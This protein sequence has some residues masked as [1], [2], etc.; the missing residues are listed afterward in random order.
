MGTTPSKEADGE[1]LGEDAC[2]LKSSHSSFSMFSKKKKRKANK[3]NSPG[4]ESRERPTPERVAPAVS[5]GSTC[6]MSSSR[7]GENSV[8]KRLDD[9]L[10]LEGDAGTE[11]GRVD[12]DPNNESAYGE[13]MIQDDAVKVNLGMADLMAY[14][15]VVANNSSNLPLTTRDDPELG[16]TVS[17]LTAEEYSLKSRAFVPSDV[18]II[19]G[20]FAKYGRVWDLPTS[21]EFFPSYSTREPGISHGGA[22]CNSLLKVLYDNEGQAI[23][24]S[25]S[26]YAGSTNL[27]EDED[28]I[29]T[30]QTL[31]TLHRNALN[32]SKS[33]DSLVLGDISTPAT[34][35]WTELLRKMKIEMRSVGFSQSPTIT[36]SRKFDTN[37][38][39][40]L[41][42][43]GFD[44]TKNKKLSLLI[45]CNYE[46]SKG[47]ELKASHDDITSVKDYIVNVHGFPET[48]GLMTV[49][50]DDDCHKHPTHSNITDA[51]KALSERCQPGDAVFIQFS[52]HGCR[53]LD[54]PI[55]AD[56]ESYDEA[57]VPS[58]FKRSGIIRDTLIF[59]TLL[60]P[61][62]GG[63]TIT[64]IMDC[65]DTGIMIDL[66]YAWS[67]AGDCPDIISK[68]SLNDNFSFVRFLKVI[69]TLY[70][71][72]TFTQLGQTVR[73]VLDQKNPKLYEDTKT[74]D[75]DDR[76]LLDDSTLGDGS[77]VTMES[78]NDVLVRN[79][80]N[81][82][83][84]AFVSCN[85]PKMSPPRSHLRGG[86]S[87]E[88]GANAQ[89]F[90]QQF[91][92]CGFHNPAESDEETFHRNNTEDDNDSLNVTVDESVGYYREE[93]KDRGLQY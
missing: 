3:E 5:K 27:F 50:L 55:D 53:V 40:T 73:S 67:T 64:A 62:R 4:N 37:S 36:S 60:A 56:V 6:S 33:F 79:T 14:L 9:Y 10:K 86:L 34:I 78:E 57:I 1:T 87:L 21:E 83:M 8:D 38:P 75:D 61:M 71:S 58:D 93:N 28:T 7:E 51:F 65:C 26:D 32:G 74:Y 66:P 91:M 15:Q 22:C 19:S 49:L 47:A 72:S 20:S 54:S 29:C 23:E 80:A 2:E 69:K 77:L 30:A 92:T 17:T 12:P 63:V 45:G 88:K 18:K 41:I 85:N 25:N 90:I 76:T 24:T 70:E 84:R 89:S 11:I 43:P 48:K 35:T 46:K 16:R 52:G 59:K 68:M 39:F 82:L 44:S 42:P 13:S 31:Q 81:T